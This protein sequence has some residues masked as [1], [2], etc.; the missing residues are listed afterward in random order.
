MHQQKGPFDREAM[1]LV[2]VAD[3]PPADVAD[4]PP[5]E[6]SPLVLADPP[7]AE[8]TPPAAEVSTAGEDGPPI[9]LPMDPRI[10]QRRVEVRRSEGRRRLRI[11]FG[12]LGVFTL[13]G[14]ALA[15]AHSPL[16]DVRHVRVSGAAHTDPDT[17]VHAA[18]LDRRHHM[19]DISG[20]AIA[21]R[22]RRL[23]WV[24][25]VH[26]QVSW[27]ST[28]RLVITERSPA[29]VV[30]AGPGKVPTRWALADGSGRVV[31][32]IDGPAPSMVRLVGIPAPGPPGSKL[33]AAADGPLTVLAA[34]PTDLAAR[35][36]TVELVP[37]AVV[38][39]T[40]EIDLDLTTGGTV[41]LGPLDA[42]ADKI[43]ALRTVL[44]RVDLHAMATID[45]RVPTAPVLTRKA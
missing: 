24:R 33:D 27:P 34:L 2:D 28:V 8:G 15:V 22:V 12:V 41:R 16:L 20:V 4:P 3:P 1:D 43:V 25:S 39:T 30:A 45:V 26:V 21:R 7:P 17:V 42:L 31:E 14:A 18:G 29:I 38:G 10:R 6:D 23:P 40:P 19:I 9:I 36:A 37:A 44:A 35:V 11:L 5:A 13:G 32:V